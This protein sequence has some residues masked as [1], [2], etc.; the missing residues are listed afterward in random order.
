MNTCL[1]CLALLFANCVKSWEVANCVKSFE[2]R[3]LRQPF[4][5]QAALLWQKQVLLELFTYRNKRWQ[6]CYMLNYLLLGGLRQEIN[7]DERGLKTYLSILHHLLPT[8]SKGLIFICFLFHVIHSFLPRHSIWI[9]IQN[10]F[11]HHLPTKPDHN[12]IT[13]H[14]DWLTTTYLA[15]SYS[16]ILPAAEDKAGQPPGITLCPSVLSLS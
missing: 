1:F 12:Q 11:P 4:P 7:R 3:Y 8:I 5:I 15:S 9:H 2:V 6:E 10:V 16:I 13:H 14:P